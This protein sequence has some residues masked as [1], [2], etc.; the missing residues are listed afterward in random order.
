MYKLPKF[1]T[2]YKLFQGSNPGNTFDSGPQAIFLYHVPLFFRSTSC[3][4]L[5]AV[6]V[7]EPQLYSLWLQITTPKIVTI[8]IIG[9]N[10]D[11]A[12][13]YHTEPIKITKSSQGFTLT[14]ST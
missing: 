5:T 9:N 1:A 6:K 2:Y 3:D 13:K 8:T 14:S 11:A 12:V 7:T 4:N 10:C